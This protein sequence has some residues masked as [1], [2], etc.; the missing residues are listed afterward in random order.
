MRKRIQG[1]DGVRGIA[2]VWVMFYH[3][4]DLLLPAAH[5]EELFPMLERG[6][7][8]VDLF[9]LLSGFVMAHAYGAALAINPADT[10]REFVVARFARLYP[11][12]A[13]T[14]LCAVMI[15]LLLR[16]PSATSK[17]QWDQWA[18]NFFMLQ[19]WFPDLHLNG[20][21]WSICSEVM[22][23]GLFIFLARILLF[24]PHF[25]KMLACCAAMLLVVTSVNHG[26][27]DWA[28]GTLAFVRTVAGFGIGVLLYRLDLS[29]RT[30]S[31]DIALAGSLL[32][33]VLA[34]A[35]TYDIFMIGA[36][37]GIILYLVRANGIVAEILNSRPFVNLGD[38]SYGIYLWHTPLQLGVAP[39]LALLYPAPPELSQLQAR[40]L[41]LAAAVAVVALA[42]VCH[43]Y[44]EL[45]LRQ[46]VRQRLRWWSNPGPAIEPVL[47]TRN[48]PS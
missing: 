12:Y 37:A 39:M 36:F 15:N 47:A 8:A 24:G 14:L 2:A 1:L 26:S 16:V 7:L 20:P 21:A 9:F 45:P 38:W 5:L 43:R 11:L 25:V 32:M 17:L 41:C 29:D 34:I 33:V 6:Y 40:G 30:P 35:T 3:F 10:W 42:T 4:N 18:V 22:A 27:L 48:M 13:L 19:L 44:F 46:Q 31:P 23:C 28:I